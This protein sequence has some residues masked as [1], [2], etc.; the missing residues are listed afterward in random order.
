MLSWVKMVRI[1]KEYQLAVDL[2]AQRIADGDLD[3]ISLLPP[4]ST[5]KFELDGRLY[6]ANLIFFSPMRD[7][8]YCALVLKLERKLILGAYRS[9]LAGFSFRGKKVFPIT[10][11]LLY[12]CD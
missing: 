3:W 1:D 5:H 11:E 8:D 4:L 7:R 6:E 9:Y 2:E 12:A 10:T